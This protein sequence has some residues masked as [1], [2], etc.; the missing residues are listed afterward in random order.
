MF[1]SSRAVLFKLGLREKRHFVVAEILE[2]LNKEGKLEIKFVN[3]FRAVMSS[4][5]AADYH[6]AYSKE[7]AGSSLEM[8]KE[9]ADR[10]K[11]LLN[12]LK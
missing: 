5:E 12:N 11:I 4:R 8:A 3:D 10:I 9:F 2:E 7:I 1:H 6:Y